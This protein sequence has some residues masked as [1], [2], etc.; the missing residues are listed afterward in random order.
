[1]TQKT[2]E[3]DVL[4]NMCDRIN[5]TITDQLEV[6]RFADAMSSAGF[7]PEKTASGITGTEGISNYAKVS[8]IMSCVKS[9]I[10]SS[11]VKSTQEFDSFLRV[12]R[13]LRLDDLALQLEGNLGEC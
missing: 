10:T 5:D 9:H 6:R 12:L 11:Q 3:G 2:G 7:I 8:R 1:M 13:D 4:Q